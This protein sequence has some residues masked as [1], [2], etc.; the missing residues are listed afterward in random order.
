MKIGKE[1]FF[2]IEK[3]ITII[4]MVL[5]VFLSNSSYANDNQTIIEQQEEFKIQD[6]IKNAEKFT[7]EFFEDIDINEILND[8]IKGEVD[9]STLLKKILNILGKEV[10]T[11]IKSLVS[12]LAIILI[13]SILKSISESLENN[14]ISKLIY[15]VQYILIVTVIMS[16]FTDI[17]KL[18]QDTTGNLI[19]FMNTLVPLLITLMMYTGSITTSSVV[20]PIILFMINFIGNIIQ[21]L[22]I[23]FVLVLTSLVIISK[24]SDKVHIDK[25][26][27]FF[28]SGIVWFLGIVLTVFVGVVSLEGTL[29][30][31][32]DGITAKTTKAVVSSA[33]PV[34]G[35]ILGDAV[36]TVLGCG[37][38]L[39]NAVGLVGVVIVIGICIMPI[40][41]L[42]VLS[43]SY[44]LLSTV[45]QPIAD[46]KIIDLLEQI[47]DIFKIFLGILC[48][49]S[50][51]LIIGTT[52][53]LKISN[54]TMMYR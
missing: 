51:M 11:N 20:E 34:V 21:N 47:G 30:S 14:N 49:I 4:V 7:G 10:T 38:V 18:V 19:G 22:I 5:I 16:N 3:I 52:L 53:V 50:F 24:I 54:G 23:P 27:K 6:F 41:K 17:I 15:Y 12:I 9:N 8:A 35:K 1:N 37:I 39:K 32:V 48:A 45:V 36:D 33:I 29:S 46:E 44:K 26:S 2:I 42:F 28:K 25:L 43:V 40:L 31:S 13:H